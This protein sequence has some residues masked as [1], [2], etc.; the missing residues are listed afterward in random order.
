MNTQATVTISAPADRVW[1]VFTDVQQWPSWTPSVTSVEALDGPAIEVGHR[2]RIK[3]PWLPGLVWQ[4]TE[5]DAPRSWTWMVRSVGATTCAEHEISPRGASGC[6][7]TQTIEQ[8]GGLG[9][10]AGFLTRRLTRRYLAL[11]GNGLKTVSEKA[12]PV[13]PQP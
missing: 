3:Q 5:V 1:A 2:F 12:H 10:L 11:E 13:A 9:V 4:V 6:V 7:V 8:N